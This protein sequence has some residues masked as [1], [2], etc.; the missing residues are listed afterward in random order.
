MLPLDM[1]VVGMLVVAYSE[2]CPA[3]SGTTSFLLAFGFLTLITNVVKFVF[4]LGRPGQGKRYPVLG[5][6]VAIAGLAQLGLG[7]W[8]VSLIYPNLRYFSGPKEECGMGVVVAVFIPATIIML[9]ICGLVGAGLYMSYCKTE[10]GVEGKGNGGA[11]ADL[12][13]NDSL[14]SARPSS[15]PSIDNV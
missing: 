2:E 7:L 4:S 1:S 9:V 13:R 3:I 5:G 11:G 15:G 8:G 6:V 14:G 12:V 10:E